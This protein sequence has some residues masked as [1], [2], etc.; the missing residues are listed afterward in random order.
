MHYCSAE[1]LLLLDCENSPLHSFLDIERSPKAFLK[2][3]ALTIS[4]FPCPARPQL[5]R[6]R[7]QPLFD[8]REDDRCLWP[9]LYLHH[10]I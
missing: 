9:V 8:P 10:R 6:E 5:Q 1:R 7:V 4:P 2:L 3:E